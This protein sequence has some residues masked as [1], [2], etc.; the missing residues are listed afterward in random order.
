MS[1]YALGYPH[2]PPDV[3]EQ[4]EQGRAACVPGNPSRYLASGRSGHGQRARCVPDGTVR[5]GL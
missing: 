2:T 5:G 1:D 3:D 4:R